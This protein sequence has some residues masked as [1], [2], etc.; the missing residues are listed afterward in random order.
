[1]MSTGD[2]RFVTSDW[3]LIVGG[4][5]ALAVAENKKATSKVVVA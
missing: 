2:E 4:V 5:W 3:K 1:M